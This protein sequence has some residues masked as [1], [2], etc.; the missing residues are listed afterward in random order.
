MHLPIGNEHPI[1][2][3]KS[4]TEAN[5]HPS[6]AK[7]GR[8]GRDREGA[9][10][11]N[12]IPP[13]GWPVKQRVSGIAHIQTEEGTSPLPR[14][15]CHAV[16]HRAWGILLRPGTSSRS[17][18]FIQNRPPWPRIGEGRPDRRQ[19]RFVPA[20]AV[21]RDRPRP[22]L[23][24]ITA[25]TRVEHKLVSSPY[26]RRIN[27]GRRSLAESVNRQAGGRAERGIKPVRGES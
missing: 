21:G 15:N 1:E 3:N 9:S 20:V 8:P 13:G 17:G 26:P 23:A 19:D 18:H 10:E 5:K 7:N 25:S 11:R 16:Q 27:Y 2:A 24:I 14:P 12:G 22:G 4:S 6:S